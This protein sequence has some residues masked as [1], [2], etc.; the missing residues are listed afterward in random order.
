ML[1]SSVVIFFVN[2]GG[3]KKEFYPLGDTKK[4]SLNPSPPPL[5]TESGLIKHHIYGLMI[6]NVATGCAHVW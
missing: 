1:Q 3:C 2:V 5:Q 6:K 4:Y